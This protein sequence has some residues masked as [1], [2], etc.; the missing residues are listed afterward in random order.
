MQWMKEHIQFHR[1]DSKKDHYC[2]FQSKRIHSMDSKLRWGLE[3][4]YE[5]KMLTAFQNEGW[6][7]QI[8][9]RSNIFL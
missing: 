8:I 1:Y 5:I 2:D 4:F 7:G 9:L 3:T 6:S